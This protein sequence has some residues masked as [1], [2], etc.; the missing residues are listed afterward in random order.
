VLAAAGMEQTIW[1]LNNGITLLASSVYYNDG[2]LQITDPLIVNGL[3]TSYEVFNH[4]T[5]G[6]SKA[7]E[8][9]FWS[10]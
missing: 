6:A 9:T 2:A 8:R 5:S 10:E 1:W 4:F 7:D 3:Q